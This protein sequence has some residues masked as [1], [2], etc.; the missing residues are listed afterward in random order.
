MNAVLSRVARA[1]RRRIFS[2][3]PRLPDAAGD[4][5]HTTGGSDPVL[6]LAVLGDSTAA[7]VGAATHDDALAGQLATA[8]AGLTGRAVSW[9]AIA[10]SGATTARVAATLTRDLVVPLEGWRPDVVV[11]VVGVND[12]IRWRPLSAWRSDVTEVFRQVRRQAPDAIVVV[13]GLPP[14]GD[15]PLLPATI[16]PVAGFRARRM[17]AVLNEVAAQTGNSHVPLG[18]ASKAHWFAQDG[19]HPSAAGYRAWSRILAIAVADAVDDAATQQLHR[20]S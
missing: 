20:A 6:R 19:F 8:V 5:G 4:S 12:L 16:R 9:R 18:G 17:D 13:S 11:I 10:E 14:V 1:A 2:T 7:G 15:F 3:A